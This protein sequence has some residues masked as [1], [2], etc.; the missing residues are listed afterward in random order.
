MKNNHH[1]PTIIKE[2]K[3]KLPESPGH[4]TRVF[5]DNEHLLIAVTGE[6]MPVS[7]PVAVTTEARPALKSIYLGN[8]RNCLRNTKK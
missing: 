7:L 2:G 5:F 8:G 6:P 1:Y 4:S 3:L